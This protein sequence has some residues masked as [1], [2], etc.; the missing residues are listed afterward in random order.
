MQLCDAPL[1]EEV[2]PFALRIAL[3]ELA[4]HPCVGYGFSESR[5]MASTKAIYENL[6]RQAFRRDIADPPRDG[7]FD[8]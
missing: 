8:P 2:G 3:S 6:E 1:P 5:D 4:G 7:A